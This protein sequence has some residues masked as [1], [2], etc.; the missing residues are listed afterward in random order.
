M[1][2]IYLAV[3]IAFFISWQPV[4]AQEAATWIEKG[5]IL[6]QQEIYAEAVKAYTKAIEY[7]PGSADAYLKRGIALFS[8]RKTN[9]TESLSDFTKAIELAPGNAEAYFRRGSVN[10]YMINNE[11]GLKDMETAAALGHTGARDWLASKTGT[12]QADSD[13]SFTTQS[14]I[15]FD[16]DRADI[17]PSYR[18]LLENVATALT[19]NPRLSIVLSGH[20]DS[21][22]TEEY[23]N[24]LSLKRATV[25]K[26]YLVKNSTVS[27]ER[28]AV[29]A[30][31]E[32]MPAASNDTKDD[33]AL[34]RRVEFDV[35][36]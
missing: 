20:A 14:I 2:K 18:R 33:R 25:V 7:D 10:Y 35:Y 23:N 31:G 29:K 1:K 12:Q 8:E 5:D 13:I 6:E 16:H 32:S 19:N 21:T 34:N 24:T 15:Y 22:G 30:Y 17:Q 26:G 28:I 3:I 36:E 11:Q 4:C 27:P 9:C